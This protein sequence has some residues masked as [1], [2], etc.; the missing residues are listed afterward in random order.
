M[1]EG[2]RSMELKMLAQCDPADLVRI[3]LSHA[4]EWAIV[5]ARSQIEFPL[6][7]VTGNDAPRVVQMLGDLGLQSAFD[8]A[9]V[10]SYGKTYILHELRDAPCDVHGGPIFE[11]NGALIFTN[12][13]RFLRCMD[14]D[15]PRFLCLKTGVVGTEPHGHKAAFAE[16]GVWHPDIDES[17]VLIVFV[18]ER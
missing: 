15:K 6:V 13:G 4:T 5:G 14:R 7:V 11:Q 10:L 12:Q 18:P 16:W 1:A 17:H 9:P 8:T 3:N 2:Q